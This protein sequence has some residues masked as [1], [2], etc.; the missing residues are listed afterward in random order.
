MTQ[1]QDALL[2]F[3]Y[4]L[5]RLI[6][7]QTDKEITNPFARDIHRQLFL[8]RWRHIVQRA[9]Y[10]AAGMAAHY[11]GVFCQR[12][13]S[14]I[15]LRNFAKSGNVEQKRADAGVDMNKSCTTTFNTGKFFGGP[16]LFSDSTIDGLFGDPETFRQ[17]FG[18]HFA[19]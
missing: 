11:M 13:F 5:F 1:R 6:N 3:F 19:A 4:P 14:L 18:R 9:D 7:P 2:P 16:V 8:F 10:L 12:L 15:N 17:L